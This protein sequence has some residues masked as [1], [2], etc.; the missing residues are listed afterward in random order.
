RLVLRRCACGCG[1][2]CGGNSGYAASARGGR[3]KT[4][5][6][7]QVEDVLRS[8]GQ[9]LAAADR[10]EFEQRYGHDFGR[11]RIHADARAADSARALHA[12]A[13]T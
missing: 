8:P 5:V 9:P 3:V 7:D 11:V 6:P 1:G 4:A 12:Q 2:K 10:A 13:Y